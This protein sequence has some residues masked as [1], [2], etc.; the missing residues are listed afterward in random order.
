MIPSIINEE[1]DSP[2]WTQAV[3][4]TAGLSE[5]SSAD[6]EKFVTISISQSFP[7]SVLQRTALLTLSRLA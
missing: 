7:A 5:I 1:L 4:M 3:R 2:G 6:D